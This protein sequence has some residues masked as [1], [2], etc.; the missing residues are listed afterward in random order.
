MSDS[1]SCGWCGAALPSVRARFC[2]RRCRQTAWR[3]RRRG[4][5]RAG[6]DDAASWPM[7]LAYA[8]PPYP[9]R[10]ALYRGEVGPVGEV[11]PCWLLHELR[12]YDG[13]ALSTNDE[14]LRALVPSLTHSELICPWVHLGAAPRS[15]GPARVV[16]YVVVSPARRLLR[17]GVPDGLSAYPARGGGDLIGRKPLA[18]CGWLFAL[19]GARC[20]DT[21]CDLYPGS[22][23]IT[24]AWREFVRAG[25]LSLCT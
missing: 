16:E 18:F 19:L 5:T 3:L 9:G 2:S 14:G 12:S 6:G 4:V 21:L 24:R 20:D 13:W 10:S 8:D 11:D 25:S 23:V 15:Y 7:S 22:G 17:T 1:L